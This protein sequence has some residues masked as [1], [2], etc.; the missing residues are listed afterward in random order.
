M[1]LFHQEVAME[2]WN[3]TFTAETRKFILR[4]Q[5]RT[6]MF[7]VD[8]NQNLSVQ[9]L[10][11]KR[12]IPD[13][14]TKESPILFPKLEWPL[15]SSVPPKKR[16]K[17]PL[18]RLS[19][20]TAEDREQ[21]VWDLIA[22]PSCQENKILDSLQDV[23]NLNTS[24]D[25]DDIFAP[26][27]DLHPHTKWFPNYCIYHGDALVTFFQMIADASSQMIKMSA[28]CYTDLCKDLQSHRKCLTLADAPKNWLDALHILK[29]LVPV[30]YKSQI[31]TCVGTPNDRT[32]SERSPDS[33][34][35]WTIGDAIARQLPPK[36][37]KEHSEEF[38]WLRIFHNFGTSDSKLFEVEP[39]RIEIWTD[40]SCIGNPGPG[41]WAFVWNVLGPKDDQLVSS[42]RMSGSEKKTTNNRME[43][44][45]IIQALY[46][47][48]FAVRRAGEYLPVT[49]WTDSTYC[50]NGITW[51]EGWKKKNWL[52][53]KN[54]EI[55]NQ[56][57]WKQLDT[58]ILKV[59]ESNTTT[60]HSRF[61]IKWVK[62]H[63][64]NK[65]NE[66]ADKCANAAAKS[67]E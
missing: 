42:W 41:G 52:N 45:S 50:S 31:Q 26:Y 49:I 16:L 12:K 14:P 20:A 9:I 27:D 62:G 19:F 2:E 28:Y 46:H 43:L 55:K 47:L 30:K 8:P 25:S 48:N 15:V 11:G 35:R 32:W 51:R 36:G 34:T 65:W 57:L 56:D 10:D 59:G 4:H 21:Y 3:D 54:Q 60:P 64:G 7:C 18:G 33:L 6:N 58:L 37:L 39:A 22:L 61:Q 13:S 44:T 63:N 38:S 53:S 5:V 40:G 24:L 29:Q 67:I 23:L 1:D 66:E 17:F